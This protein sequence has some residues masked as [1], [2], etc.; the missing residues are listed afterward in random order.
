MINVAIPIWFQELEL[1][2]ENTN[3][4]HV[5]FLGID[6]VNK[7]YSVNYG[8]FKELINSTGAAGMHDGDR[9]FVPILAG[10]VIGAI[11]DTVSG[12]T[13]P[14]FS[15]PLPLLSMESSR[16]IFELK[17]EQYAAVM[18]D[19]RFGR[20]VA[21]MG[22]HCRALEELYVQMGNIYNG[23]DDYYDNVLEA[24]TL[25]LSDKYR[26]S[27]RN[28]FPA[29]WDVIALSFLS[30]QSSHDQPL[31]HSP[32]MN[33]RRI[34]EMGMAKVENGRVLIP[35]IFVRLILRM[36][37]DDRAKY[38][39]HWN[40]YIETDKLLWQHWE[41]F[42]LKYMALRVSMFSYYRGKNRTIKVAEF[43][44]GAIINVDDAL[45]F[46][47]PSNPDDITY[48][49]LKQRIND[50][51]G[52]GGSGFTDYALCLNGS[53]ASND[54]FCRLPRK[55]KKVKKINCIFQMKCRQKDTSVIS[56]QQVL[57]EYAKVNRDNQT[58]FVLLANRKVDIPDRLPAN[59]VI[60]GEEYV[61][62]SQRISLVWFSSLFNCN[63]MKLM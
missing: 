22:G 23:Q 8:R 47:L 57:S 17:N 43:F 37:T 12:S 20:L 4:R 27:L 9:F 30:I 25:S 58:V 48:S 13:F 62:V 34:E 40:K 46:E 41:I 54:G 11:E 44:K 15:I 49:E 14:Q 35:Y 32:R 18:D 26:G 60:V 1:P 55:G 3:S 39:K 10:T 2:H 28:R 33:M 7:V 24:V 56:E 16:R 53:G 21:Q 61:S 38:A 45:D 52:D 42:N 5:F 29:Y 31:H 63:V 36:N 6:E 51:A 59:I 50:P 19:P